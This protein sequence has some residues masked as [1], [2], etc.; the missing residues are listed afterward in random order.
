MSYVNMWAHMVWA[1]HC[2]YPYLTPDI[3]YRVFD[4]IKENAVKKGI[5]LDH[6]NGHLEHVH[7]LISLNADQN[8]MTVANLLKGESSF[9]INKNKLTPT[10]FYWQDDYFAESVSPSQLDAVR[11]YI[12]NQDEHH[13]KKS[14]QEEYDEFISRY[15]LNGDNTRP[16]LKG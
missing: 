14:F 4:H 3:R 13:R 10:K 5:Y 2:R 9:W 7:C 11:R 6:I 15:E 12:R 16:E 1:T 8:V